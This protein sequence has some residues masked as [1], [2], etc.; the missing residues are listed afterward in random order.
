VDAASAA[1]QDDRLDAA[2]VSGPPPDGPFAARALLEDPIVR[3]V[4]G[5][6]IDEADELPLIV[7]RAA[8]D[9]RTA[10][11]RG[12][13]VHAT[14]DDATAHALVAAGL[15]AAI[16]PAL[17]VAA[18]DDRLIA[19]PVEAPPRLLS[20]VWHAERERTPAFERFLE[21]ALAWASGAPGE[22]CRVRR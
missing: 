18:G 22:R 8:H 4:R 7:R 20:V 6:A 21:A 15:G 14:D 13:V 1:L 10:A 16:L 11:V 5:D 12:R 17:S 3:L 19:L 2:R 9:T